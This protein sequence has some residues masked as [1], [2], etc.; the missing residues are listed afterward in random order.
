MA[1][2]IPKAAEEVVVTATTRLGSIT[3]NGRRSRASAKLN[4]AEVAP[5]PMAREQ[6]AT[7]VKLGFLRSIRAARRTAFNM[8][9]VLL[10]SKCRDESRRG[11]QSGR[12]TIG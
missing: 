3:G 1:E 6:T 2:F 9:M 12:A 10:A 8:R 11:G 7:M 4:I 5:M